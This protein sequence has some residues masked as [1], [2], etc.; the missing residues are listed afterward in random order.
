MRL[1]SEWGRSLL[2]VLRF[3]NGGLDRVGNVLAAMRRLEDR[4]PLTTAT[5][6]EGR[7]LTSC[8]RPPLQ[9]SQIAAT[10]LALTGMNQY[11]TAELRPRLAAARERA[12]KWLTQAPLK[13]QEDCIWRL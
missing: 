7:W 4:E 5:I 9:S 6:H 3:C 11:A 10:V 2:A 13:T 12:D 8:D 1:R